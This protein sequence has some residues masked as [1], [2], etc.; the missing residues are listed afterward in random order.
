MNG[1]TPEPPPNLGERGAAFWRTIMGDYELDQPD[2]AE[3]LLETCR[4]LDL[5]EALQEVIDREGVLAESSQGIRCHPAV[6]ELRQ[7]RLAAARLLAALGVDSGEPA[8]AP[9]G[10]YSL[11]GGKL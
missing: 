4:Q 11:P 3:L 10:F 8:R 1:I 5:L 9:R 6:T 7:A 2:E